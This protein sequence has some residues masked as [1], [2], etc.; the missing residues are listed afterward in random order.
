MGYCPSIFFCGLRVAFL[1]VLRKPNSRF[2]S[3][4]LVFAIKLL[5]LSIVEIQMSAAT[6]ISYN[7]HSELSS[8]FELY[9][10]HSKRTEP[11]SREIDVNRQL[12][13]RFYVR[14]LR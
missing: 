5:S 6:H 10:I 8:T 1:F 4:F 3:A 7:T 13:N 2:I 9:S 14:L 11:V 12:I